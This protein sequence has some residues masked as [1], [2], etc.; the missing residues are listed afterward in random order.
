MD[1]VATAADEVQVIQHHAGGTVP[2]DGALDR[3]EDARAVMEPSWAIIR[4]Q[5]EGHP[6]RLAA[7]KG[8]VV[9]YEALG[10]GV[11][12]VAPHATLRS[13]SRPVP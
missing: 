6:T 11:A 1:R 3:V 10:L 4:R 9:L 7:A 13:A 2:P 8:M 5:P 12:S